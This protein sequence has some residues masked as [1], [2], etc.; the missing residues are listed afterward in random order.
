IWVL[1]MHADADAAV[2]CEV[3]RRA[4]V[5]RLGLMARDADCRVRWE[6]ALR[7]LPDVLMRLLA[8]A[9]EPVRELAGRR[10]DE[11]DYLAEEA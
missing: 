10:L 6:V 5:E 1:T 2:R 4:P 8:D 9:V 7:A 11:P 3:A